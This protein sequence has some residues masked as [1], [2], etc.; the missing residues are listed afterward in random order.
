MA[1]DIGS[2]FASEADASVAAD[3]I[4]LHIKRF[5][6]PRMR[7]RIVVHFKETGGQGLEG[8]VRTAV[9]RLAGEAEAARA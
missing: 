6:D 4:L 3:N 5:W 8:P 1:N 7:R 9:Q 2:F